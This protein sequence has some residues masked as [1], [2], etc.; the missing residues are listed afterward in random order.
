MPLDCEGLSVFGGL[1]VQGCYPCVHHFNRRD[2]QVFFLNF[3][4]LCVLCVL[5]GEIG[6]STRE[7]ETALFLRMQKLSR[8]GLPV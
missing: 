2:R 3:E 1:P 6:L 5:C 8:K 7:R 4:I